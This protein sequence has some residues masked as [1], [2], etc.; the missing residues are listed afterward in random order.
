MHGCEAAKDCRIVSL[1]DIST[2]GTQNT[3]YTITGNKTGFGSA[4]TFFCLSYA[5]I[6]G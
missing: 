3:N 1:T 4:E 6:I 2:P 5:V